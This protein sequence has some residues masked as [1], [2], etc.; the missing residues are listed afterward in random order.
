[1]KSIIK[2]SDIDQDNEY[3]DVLGDWH[4]RLSLFDN[5]LMERFQTAMTPG[6]RVA[7]DEQMLPF[8]GRS[9]HVTKVPG[10]PYPDGFKV[11]ALCNRGYLYG[12]L[13]YSGTAS[14][15]WCY[16]SLLCRG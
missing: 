3:V 8:T 9:A 5:R 13:Y 2:V 14:M 4:F 7:Y 1:L 11:W 16:L 15:L 10:K 12:W 6:S